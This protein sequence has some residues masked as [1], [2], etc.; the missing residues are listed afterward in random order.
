MTFTNT[1]TSIE[2][3]I[4]RATSAMKATDEARGKL[5]DLE[6]TQ[7]DIYTPEKI[8]ADNKA[9][10]DELK[11]S[12]LAWQNDLVKLSAD[13]RQ[14][15]EKDSVPDKDTSTALQTV[16]LYIQSAGANL[17]LLH[18]KWL[19]RPIYEALDVKSYIIVEEMLRNRNE[20]GMVSGI[21]HPREIVLLSQRMNILSEQIDTLAKAAG[22]FAET[23]W[24]DASLTKDY[25]A[26]VSYAAIGSNIKSLIDYATETNQHFLEIFNFEEDNTKPAGDWNF[27][28]SPYAKIR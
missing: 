13:I 10:V 25:V 20:A 19:L 6:R 21:E 12:S 17:D 14:S 26:G 23:V 15:F 5:N 4:S 2:S 28:F 7:R 8:N 27:D 11:K 18:V 24:I 22:T 3:Y 1:R 9:I 16:L